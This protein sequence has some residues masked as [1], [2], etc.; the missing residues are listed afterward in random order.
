LKKQETLRDRIKSHARLEQPKKERNLTMRLAIMTL[1]AT[2]AG[3]PA[4]A[5]QTGHI[6]FTCDNVLI[7][8]W[9]SEGTVYVIRVD[10]GVI[11]KAK[12]G[13]ASIP[14]PIHCVP[15]EPGTGDLKM[16][17]GAN[18]PGTPEAAYYRQAEVV[19]ERNC[20]RAGGVM[21]PGSGFCNLGLHPEDL[22][23][24]TD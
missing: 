10:E 23:A 1:A 15:P 8:T 16:I 5:Q 2:L 13:D 20:F 18:H 4:L 6:P 11:S 12:L 14:R 7:D 19:Y 24:K 9:S 17:Y 21:L 3:S 22:P